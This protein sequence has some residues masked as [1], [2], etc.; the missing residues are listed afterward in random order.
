MNPRTTRRSGTLPSKWSSPLDTQS[1]CQ[2]FSSAGNA[3][4]ILAPSKA[5]EVNVFNG[6]FGISPILFWDDWG[7]QVGPLGSFENWRQK[8][9]PAD[10]ERKSSQQLAVFPGSSWHITRHLT[11]VP[12]P[13][14]VLSPNRQNI[15]VTKT[16]RM[17][18]LGEGKTNR[19][20]PAHPE[21]HVFWA[22]EF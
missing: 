13:L 12:V 18:E 5:C 9:M 3:L 15:P 20:R 19:S 1:T 21:R 4:G 8:E 11:L 14:M 2:T 10:S 17:R 16:W 7:F 22:L 6:N